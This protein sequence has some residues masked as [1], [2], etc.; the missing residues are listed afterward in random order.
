[1]HRFCMG[2]FSRSNLP[3]VGVVWNQR[4]IENMDV[5]LKVETPRL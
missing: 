2:S 1:M 5:G 4:K 3:A